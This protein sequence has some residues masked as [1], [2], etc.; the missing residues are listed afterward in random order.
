MASN[1]PA[2]IPDL[3]G[4]DP[5]GAQR[6]RIRRIVVE[7]AAAGRRLDV[8]LAAHLPGVS[9]SRAKALIESGNVAVDDVRPKPSHAVRP[10]ERIEVR[11]PSPVQH[12]EP[13]AEP[14][15]IAVVYED[16]DV[17][18]VDKPAGIAVHPGAGRVGGT[19]V[20]ALLAALPRLSGLDR[21]RPGI[22]HRLDKDTSGLLV[23]AK[24]DAAHHALAGQ[25]R[26]RAAVREYTALLRGAVPWQERT[27]AAPIGR[28]PVHRRRMAVREGGREATTHFWVTERLGD[29]TLV[30]CWL[31]S[32]RTHQ[33]RV[34]AA[35]I[36]HPV[37]GDPVY[38]RRGELGL[39]RQFLHASRLSFD[40]P[41]TGERL[42]F[43]S[44]LPADLQEALEALRR[45]R[46]RT[47]R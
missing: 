24:T 28:H 43:N 41:R 15:P 47:S 32:G 29:F 44:P 27:V 30:R 8:Y 23:V 33:I 16:D 35:H 42:T 39:A 9:R 10:G 45:S 22:V 31:A 4:E 20:N 1:P 26:S 21:M 37:A 19:L 40:H 5:Q 18:V 17:A 7:P 11:I 38:G 3:T 2:K 6:L 46:H 25:I 14:I 12:G 34:H 36:G 13:Q